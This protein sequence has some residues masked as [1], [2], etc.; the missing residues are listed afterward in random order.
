MQTQTDTCASAFTTSK[1][2]QY[3][4]KFSR[5]GGRGQ[6]PLIV[7]IMVDYF[8]LPVHFKSFSRRSWRSSRKASDIFGATL[9]VRKKK[10]LNIKEK[11]VHLPSL[12]WV[13]RSA[14]CS[15]DKTANRGHLCSAAGFDCIGCLYDISFS[16]IQVSLLTAA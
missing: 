11:T 14:S 12:W 10:I 4:I 1:N 8:H 15:G 5:A 13:T 7:L 16:R 2:I 6:N 9:T 3:L